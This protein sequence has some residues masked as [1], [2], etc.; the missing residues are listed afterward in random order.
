V[1]QDVQQIELLPQSREGDRPAFWAALRWACC[2][3]RKET[4]ESVVCFAQIGKL[5][6]GETGVLIVIGGLAETCGLP[7]GMPKYRERW[8]PSKSELGVLS[9]GV[10]RGLALGADINLSCSIPRSWHAPIIQELLERGGT[11]DP[12]QLRILAESALLSGILELAYAASVAGLTR[13]GPGEARFLLI[14][15]QSMP[16]FEQA[17]RNVCLAAAAELARRQR[18]SGL[19][20]EIIE[21]RRGP[22]SR[23]NE[24]VDDRDFYMHSG[25]IERVLKK[26]KEARSYPEQPLRR[27]TLPGDYDGRPGLCQCPKCRRRRGELDA[28]DEFDDPDDLEESAR[29]AFAELLFGTTGLDPKENVKERT[30]PKRASV[31]GKSG[32]PPEQGSLF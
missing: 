2:L 15:A 23:W 1:E 24:P 5:L 28:V 31:R 10:A 19:L 12:L 21:A 16:Q 29:R 18:D 20:D 30:V 11:F 6:G 26:E 13:G 22:N 4:E 9:L 25:Q 32:P 7:E 14:R 3:L 27:S 17:R 8:T